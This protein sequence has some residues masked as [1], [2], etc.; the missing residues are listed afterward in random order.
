[1]K[2][3]LLLSV[4]SLVFLLSCN[5]YGMSENVQNQR[6]YDKF[7]IEESPIYIGEFEL[8]AYCKCVKCCGKWSNYPCK[9]GEYPSQNYTIAVD[10]K[11]IPLNSFVEINGVKYKAQ[12]TGSAIK[13]NIIDVY[14]DSH[15]DALE[16]G[17]KKGVKIYLYKE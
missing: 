10:T 2:R 7:F 4:A 6:G 3:S 17:R 14:F 1:M 15:S 12:D 13:G 16:F 9:N 11:V 8:T 5:T